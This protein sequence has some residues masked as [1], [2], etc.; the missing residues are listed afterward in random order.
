MR[1]VGKIVAVLNNQLLLVESLAGSEKEF[2]PLRHMGVYGTVSVLVDKS[3]TEV[4]ILKAR[5]F[6]ESTQSKSSRFILRLMGDTRTRVR[7]R[8]SEVLFPMLRE[9]GEDVQVRVP[10]VDDGQ[11]LRVDV[12]PVRIGDIIGVDP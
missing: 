8:V 4:E 1:R 12:E 7:T 9:V 6:L 3:E 11:S 2:T 10:K 5:A